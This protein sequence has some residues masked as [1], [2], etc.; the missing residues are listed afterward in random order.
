MRNF[1]LETLFRGSQP[2]GPVAH[3]PEPDAK[4]CA[5]IAANLSKVLTV[6]I[7]APKKWMLQKQ[8]SPDEV[9]L[10]FNH[11]DERM[12]ISLNPETVLWAIDRILGGDASSP[13]A[14]TLAEQGL[15]ATR[16]FS[17]AERGV[18]LWLCTS[19]LP[20]QNNWRVVGLLGDKSTQN[21]FLPGGVSM[22]WRGSAFVGGT[23]V[24]IGIVSQLKEKTA[25]V[26]LR[27]GNELLNAQ[28]ICPIAVGSDL[29]AARELTA[30]EAGD[31]IIVGQAADRSEEKVA[32][33][34][35]IG[36]RWAIAANLANGRLTV[37]Q[38]RN[39][40]TTIGSTS[41][42]YGQ[43]D[44]AGDGIMTEL[45]V[46]TNSSNDDRSGAGSSIMDAKIRLSAELGHVELTAAQILSLTPGSIIETE[47]KLHENVTVRAGGIAVA[48]GELIEL[49]GKIGVLIKETYLQNTVNEDKTQEQ[50]DPNEIDTV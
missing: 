26:E 42:E 16:H 45:P 50:P 15:I 13:N 8:S 41:I 39:G 37:V 23:P 49:E 31:L 20:P 40:S 12:L 14:L 44:Q 25:P 28:L 19:S 21:A 32:V 43:N 7:E 27:E 29:I 22:S 1:T 48:Q 18:L 3:N 35:I 11:Q 5:A 38:R 46:A 33:N 4:V 24:E 2:H 10:G 17:M 9:C 47:T 36:D 34:I 6:P 30:L